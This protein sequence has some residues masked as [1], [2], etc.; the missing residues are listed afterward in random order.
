MTWDKGIQAAQGLPFLRRS[1]RRDSRNK[2]SMTVPFEALQSARH[3]QL[4]ARHQRQN[5]KPQYKSYAAQ[6]QTSDGLHSCQLHK[7]F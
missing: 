6:S 2:T 5:E 1:Y 3:H 7:S 4:R